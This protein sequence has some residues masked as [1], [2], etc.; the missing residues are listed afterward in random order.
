MTS[1]DGFRK[2]L[3]KEQGAIKSENPEWEFHHQYFLQGK[4]ELL[5]NIK[6]K[7]TS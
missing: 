2:L 6:R 4:V 1:S 5:E 7:V 3:S